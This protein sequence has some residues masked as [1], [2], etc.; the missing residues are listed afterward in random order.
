MLLAVCRLGCRG[1]D[2]FKG[3]IRDAP[4]VALVVAL[5]LAA[6]FRTGDAAPAAILSGTGQRVLG[7]GS[8]AVAAAV[9]SVGTFFRGSTALSSRWRSHTQ[10]LEAHTRRLAVAVNEGTRRAALLAHL[11]TGIVRAVVAR[12]PRGRPALVV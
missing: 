10:R 11:R 3:Q 1:I 9:V 6:A 7:R 8:V 12:R 5:A 2:L 4:A